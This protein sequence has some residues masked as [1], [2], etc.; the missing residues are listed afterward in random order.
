MIKYAVIALLLATTSANAVS[1]SRDIYP[2]QRESNELRKEINELRDE[3]QKLKE[4]SVKLTID[5]AGRCRFKDP[6]PYDT[7]E[8]CRRSIA[9][10]DLFV[11]ETCVTFDDP[12]VGAPE[13]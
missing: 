8:E 6:K 9:A 12:L 10:P 1:M 5:C 4:R 11:N 3:I 7:L 2:L 13:N